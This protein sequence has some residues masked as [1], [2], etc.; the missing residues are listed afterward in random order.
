MVLG[1]GLQNDECSYISGCDWI[2]NGIDYSELFFDS[3]DEC[4]E[5]CGFD[6]IS[7]EQIAE[8][9]DELHLGEALA[10]EYDI[11]CTSVWGD[12]SIGLVGCH[13][14]VNISN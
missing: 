9:Y 4:E 8:A 7:C 6:N 14:S 3:I 1:F 13:Y 11:D 2:L 5:T 12:C 10:C